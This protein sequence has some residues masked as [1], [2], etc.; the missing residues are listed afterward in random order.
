MS[1]PLGYYVKYIR[2]SHRYIAAASK[3][4]DQAFYHACLFFI[5]SQITK[6]VP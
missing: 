4:K 2:S 1:I 6:W 3:E 5:D